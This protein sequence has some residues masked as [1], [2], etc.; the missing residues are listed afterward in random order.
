MHQQQKAREIE[1]F[2]E[3]LNNTEK[4]N[5]TSKMENEKE[6]DITGSYG[7]GTRNNRGE[8]VIQFYQQK[9]VIAKNMFFTLP[10][11]GLYAWRS[12][13][14]GLNGRTICNNITMFLLID[15]LQSL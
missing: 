4:Y 1:I 5:F 12:Q 11:R 15:N 2:H 10:V 8:R 6:S 14:N 3:D 13:A 7:F 9:Y